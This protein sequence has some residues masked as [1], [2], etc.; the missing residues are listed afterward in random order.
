M[1]GEVSSYGDKFFTDI[2]TRIRDIEEKQRLLRD[3]MKLISESFVKERDKNFNGIQEIKK[4]VEKLKLDNER[5]KDL[6]LR[7]GE[8]L[9]K[10]ARK[11]ELLILQRQFDLF[12][13]V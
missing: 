7:I 6:L 10:S 1:A 4:D 11:E 12:R 8:G 3:R 2:N 5:M 13:D 9:N